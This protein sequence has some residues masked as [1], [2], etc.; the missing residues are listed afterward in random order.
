[1]RFGAIAYPVVICVLILS[2]VKTLLSSEFVEE[3]KIVGLERVSEEFVRSVIVLQPGK[4]FDPITLRKDIER[5]FDLDFFEDIKAEFKDGV[6]TFFLLE[7]PIVSEFQVTGRKE[8]EEEKLKNAIFIKKGDFYDGSKLKRQINQI[9]SEYRKEGFILAKIEP[10]IT[11]LDKNRVNLELNIEEGSRFHVKRIVIS[12]AEKLRKEDILRYVQTKELNLIRRLGGESKL[13]LVKVESEDLN[14]KYAY[15]DEGFLDVQAE[16]PVV[17]INPAK[18]EAVIIYKVK[19]GIRYKVEKLDVLGDILF[20]KDK[21]LENLETKEGEFISRKKVAGDIEWITTLYQ[22]SGFARTQVVPEISKLSEKDED[23]QVEINFRIQRSGVF[24][25]TDINIFG[26]TRTRDFVIRREISLLE[27][28][29]FSRSLLQGSYFNLMKTGFFENV[30]IS[31]FFERDRKS[32]IDVEV[33]EGRTGAIS[34]GGGFAPLASNFSQSIVLMFQANLN[35][36]R[37]LGQKLGLYFV[38][39]GGYSFIDIFFRDEHAFDTDYI[40]G[41]NIS[42]YQSI[43]LPFL[44]MT[45]GGNLNFGLFL[46]KNTKLILYPGLEIVDVYS[47]DGR[48]IPLYRDDKG[49]GFSLSNSRFLKLEL[50]SDSRDNPFIPSRGY[51]LTGWSKIGGVFGGDLYFIKV[52]GVASFNFPIFRNLI[53]SPAMRIGAGIGLTSSQFLPYPERFFAGGIYSIRGF[54]YFSL[55]PR[56]KVE[57]EPVT[58]EIILGGNKSFISNMEMVIIISRQFGLMLV[59]F[60][61]VGQVFEE[62]ERLSLDKF[63]A[64][65]GIEFRWISPFGPIRVSLGFPV[66][67]KPT[68]EKRIVDFSFGLFTFYPEF[69]QF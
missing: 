41:F 57:G 66:M 33:K 4:E 27:G 68:D 69:Y 17:L 25:I 48:R 22:D 36:F 8:L 45:T 52:G 6:L 63:R 11:Y 59:P 24:Y 55:G 64:S 56:V 37:G 23:G 7:K 32:R 5:L 38:Y 54:N 50:T 61:D 20:P 30:Q 39:G 12:G 44:K 49:A 43:F 31:P 21:M 13:D 9:I 47:R 65:A 16:K 19:E 28:E 51:L 1:M 18:S 29:I 10:K 67:Y 58:R 62:R 34:L 15:L 42:R 2:S 26:N 53:F 14:I 46:S 40:L 35:N 60:L 3:L